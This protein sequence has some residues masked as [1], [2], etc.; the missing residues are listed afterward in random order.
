MEARVI[1][2]AQNIIHMTQCDK[3]H[4][5]KRYLSKGV[6]KT[7]RYGEYIIQY[8]TIKYYMIWYILPIWIN[9]SFLE[10]CWYNRGVFYKK[11][12]F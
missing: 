9:I 11:L 12:K 8:D 10:K 3:I 1:G 6:S 4:C 7:I 5:S 2:I